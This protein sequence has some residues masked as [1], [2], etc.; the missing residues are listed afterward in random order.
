MSF[1]FFEGANVTYRTQEETDL[2]REE[3]AARG[4]IPQVLTRQ[5]YF[6]KKDSEAD[7]ELKGA[8][9]EINHKAITEDYQYLLGEPEQVP[10]DEY[11]KMW[12]IWTG[13][14]PTQE[15]MDTT[16]WET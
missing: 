4:A 7:K 2:A 3:T 11:G 16:P 6:S 1:L 10:K 13:G 5:E 12:R 9:I 8:F 14:I 15:Q